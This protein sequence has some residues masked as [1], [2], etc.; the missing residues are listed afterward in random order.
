[1]AAVARRATVVLRF[2]FFACGGHLIKLIIRPSLSKRSQ[3]P[4]R[5]PET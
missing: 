3:G 1:M 2:F 5:G 4:R